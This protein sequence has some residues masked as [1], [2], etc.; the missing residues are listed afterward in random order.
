[1]KRTETEKRMR[2]DDLAKKAEQA[3]REG[4]G[5]IWGKSGQ[6]WTK[7]EQARSDR[8][9]TMAWGKQWIG[10]RVCDCSGLIVWALK[11]E[12]I[13]I[14]HG[15][16]TQWQK[17]CAEKGALKNGMRTD[18]RRL[19]RGTAVFLKDDYDSRHHVGIYVGGG[20]VIEAKSTRDGVVMSGAERWDEW[21]ELRQA[22]YGEEGV[23]MSERTMKKGC[24]GEDVKKL[25][26]R[27]NA[28]GYD[29]GAADG[30]YGARTE[31]AVIYFQENAGIRQDGIAGPETMEKLKAA[32]EKKRAE[33]QAA[34]EAPA[35]R[36]RRAM[37]R[38]AAALLN[39][40]LEGWT[41][42]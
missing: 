5:Y 29:C 42:E 13:D 15:S 36:G 8:V 37:I 2:A 25:Q 27:L 18:G 34:T 11:E 23:C 33:M 17:E 38:E 26:E 12:G 40:V 6:I 32:E 9:Q 7:E 16:N 20:Q 1:M 35:E 4:W 3:L 41:D 39:G 28:L 30:K 24:G 22:D 10:K 21:G 19:K 14:Y 31:L